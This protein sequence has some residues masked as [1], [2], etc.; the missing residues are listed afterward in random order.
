MAFLG[1]D[2][3]TESLRTIL[4]LLSLPNTAELIPA[5]K[6]ADVDVNDDGEPQDLT[7]SEPVL[8]AVTD[9]Q[10]SDND[11]RTYIHLGIPVPLSSTPNTETALNDDELTHESILPHNHVLCHCQQTSTNSLTSTLDDWLINS[12]GYDSILERRNSELSD[13]YTTMSV[14]TAGM[15]TLPSPDRNSAGSIQV[16]KTLD[17]QSEV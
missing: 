13:G 14:I 12:S 10:F 6:S 11:S 7:L 8:K 1:R 3:T 15:P 9:L 17:L 2:P 4:E 5:T 16:H